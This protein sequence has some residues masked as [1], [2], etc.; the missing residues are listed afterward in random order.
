MISKIPKWVGDIAEGMILK[1]IELVQDEK[2]SA[3]LRL[4]QFRGDVG[5]MNFQP[6][7]G[8]AIRVSK[9]DLRNYTVFNYDKEKGE[10][11]VLF[12]LNNL[13]VGSKLISSL[14]SGDVLFMDFPRGKT[15]YSKAIKNQLFFGDE[16][17]LGLACSLHSSYRSNHHQYHFYLELDEEN[18]HIPEALGLDNFEVFPKGA[19]ERNTAA[20]ILPQVEHEHMK[21]SRCLLT[22]NGRSVQLVRSLL[23]ANRFAGEIYSK[24][25]WLEGKKGL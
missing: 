25:Y 7:N 19:V 16:T 5:S 3:N 6:G 10:F 20:L 15:C 8:N 9:T 1:P 21:N 2:L 22:G 13:G 12:Y 4:C 14:S 23:K 11:M 24:G 18:K 17:S